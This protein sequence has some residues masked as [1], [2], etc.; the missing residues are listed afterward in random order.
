M[1]VMSFLV[2]WFNVGYK[3]IYMTGYCHG[4]FM[5]LLVTERIMDVRSN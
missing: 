5:Y 4:Y 3:N 2:S 1:V